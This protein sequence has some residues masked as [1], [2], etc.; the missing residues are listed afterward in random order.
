MPVTG[1]E[2][3]ANIMFAPFL[4]AET[5]LYL[6]KHRSVVKFLM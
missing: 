4:L 1:P 3:G 6:R 2:N 5:I